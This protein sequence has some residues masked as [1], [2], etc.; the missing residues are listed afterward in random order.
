VL[1]SASKFLS[2]AMLNYILL[3][4]N[5]RDN[6]NIS[7]GEIGCESIGFCDSAN[8]AYACIKTG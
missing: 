8:A 4:P 7:L 1:K 3:N 6:V 5:R 2:I